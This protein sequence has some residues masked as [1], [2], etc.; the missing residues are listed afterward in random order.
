MWLRLEASSRWL[1]LRVRLLAA[2]LLRCMSR[3]AERRKTTYQVERNRARL[4]RS[5]MH[6]VKHSIREAR[7]PAGVAAAW[8]PEGRP[9]AVLLR[10][11][12][13]HGCNFR[14]P[15]CHQNHARRQSIDG[16]WAHCFDNWP[17][18][19]WLRAFQRNFQARRLSLVITG[20]EPLVDHAPMAE[21]VHG[22]TAMPTVECIRIDTNASPA[23]EKFQAFDPR[24]I[25]LMCIFH[26]SQTTEGASLGSGLVFAVRAE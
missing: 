6:E 23:M 11:F 22:L 12:A 10:W 20:G 18:D 2:R 5:T 7:I 17:V 1:F 19:R 25:T 3:T 14:C 21:L 4:D 26:P 9:A 13:T 16:H 15:Y 8:K 24:K